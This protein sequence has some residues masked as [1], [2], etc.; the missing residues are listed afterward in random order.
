[1]P[2][3]KQESMDGV[4]WVALFSSRGFVNEE[5]MF[6]GTLHTQGMRRKDAESRIKK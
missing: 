5:I 3:G 4:Y 6:T 1:M 2:R